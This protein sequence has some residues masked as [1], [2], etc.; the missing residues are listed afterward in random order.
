MY[1]SEGILHRIPMATSPTTDLSHPLAG[2]L[3]RAD[4]RVAILDGAAR[5]FVERGYAATSM[6]EIA[7]ASGITKLIVYRHFDSK[8][9]L[10]RF[11]LQRV[12]DRLAEEFVAELGAGPE[13]I[14]RSV[15]RVAR[16]HPEG[17]RLL[18]RHAAREP[19]FAR[20]ADGL[21]ERAVA[22]SR[23]LLEPYVD[24]AMLEWAAQASTGFLVESVIAWLEHGD[25]AEDDRFVEYA[26]RA[27][28]GAVGAWATIPKA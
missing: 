21:R 23:T 8:E 24:A 13:G 9:D 14:T 18:W 6:E 17:V 22:V 11:V 3:P 27:L 5:A 12:H 26:S 19:A 25:P 4:R 10:Y 15:L 28:R 16:E 2:P 20:Y 7:A 1:T